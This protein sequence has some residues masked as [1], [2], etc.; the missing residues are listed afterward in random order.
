MKVSPADEFYGGILSGFGEYNSTQFKT[1]ISESWNGKTDSQ[2]YIIAK[3]SGLSDN[4][5][6]GIHRQ[7]FESINSFLREKL[8]HYELFESYKNSKITNVNEEFNRGVK[9]SLDVYDAN[10]DRKDG[11]R[12]SIDSIGTADDDD[13]YNKII[14]Y[15]P[16]PNAGIGSKNISTESSDD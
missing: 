5:A 10:A 16:S 1:A 15:N 4:D 13:N 12:S 6:R 2:R 7:S 3:E 11:T 8:E 9:N 14:G